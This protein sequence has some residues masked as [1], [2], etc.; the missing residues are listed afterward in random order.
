MSYVIGCGV[1]SYA[2]LE[3]NYKFIFEA[4]AARNKFL[5]FGHHVDCIFF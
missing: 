3:S 1:E 2:F 4:Q 5:E